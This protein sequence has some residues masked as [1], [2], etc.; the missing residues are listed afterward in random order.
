LI[1]AAKKVL[2]GFTAIVAKTA[3]AE[4]EEVSA[5]K[6]PDRRQWHVVSNRNGSSPRLDRKRCVGSVAG[7]LHFDRGD[8]RKHPCCRVPFGLIRRRSR[9]DATLSPSKEVTPH[10]PTTRVTHF[11]KVSGNVFYSSRRWASLTST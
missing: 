9:R 5:Y 6:S 10:I 2:D 4:F 11:A 8:S 3:E 7:F 1:E